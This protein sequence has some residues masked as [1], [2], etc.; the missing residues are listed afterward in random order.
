MKCHLIAGAP[1]CAFA[2]EHQTA[3]IVVDALRASA[4]AAMAFEAGARALLIVG[5]VETARKARAAGAGELLYGERDGLPPEGFDGG[6]SPRELDGVKG[7]TVIFTTTTGAARVVACWGA[8]A[9]AMGATVNAAAVA[10]WAGTMGR[11][12]TLIPAGL[13]HDPEFPAEEDWCAAA[14]I[15]DHAGWQVKEGAGAFAYWKNRIADE[16]APA[17]FEGAAHAAKLRA[18]GLDADIGF[19]ARS[20]LTGAVPVAV[21]R[22]QWGIWMKEPD[23]R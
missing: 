16:G 23:T 7:R 22:D 14:W 21:A 19:C 3:A 18:A 12:V 9:I 17:I 4:T 1:G 2:V 13:T 20:D 5:D 10:S 11:D 8:P 15:A 6:N